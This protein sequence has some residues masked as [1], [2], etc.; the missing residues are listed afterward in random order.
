MGVEDYETHVGFADVRKLF[1]L[2]RFG[3]SV[4]VKEPSL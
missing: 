2:R 4:F 1:R 3:S